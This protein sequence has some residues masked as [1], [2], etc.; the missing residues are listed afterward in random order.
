[1]NLESKTHRPQQE[2]EMKY[3]ISSKFIC[4]FN[5]FPVKMRAGRCCIGRADATNCTETHRARMH[6]TI[7]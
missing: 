1:M 6:E 4:R 2:T 3:S 5:V 7:L